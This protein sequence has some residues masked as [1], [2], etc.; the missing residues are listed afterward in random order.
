[1]IKPSRF[2]P[3]QNDG[4]GHIELYSEEEQE[5]LLKEIPTV[6]LKEKICY[7]HKAHEITEKKK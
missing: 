3:N 2:H 1:M 6:K 5:R 4:F 7:L